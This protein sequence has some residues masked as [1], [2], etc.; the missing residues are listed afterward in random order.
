[1]KNSTNLDTKVSKDFITYANAVIKSRAIS[2]VKDNLKPVHRRILYTMFENKLLHNKKTVK[3]SN[4]V[5]KVMI[6]H[7][8]ADAS[9]YNAMVRLAQPWKMRYPLVSVQGNSGNI[10]GDGPAAM[11]YTEARLSKLGEMMMT[12]IHKKS[13]DFKES[14]DGSTTEPIVLPSGFPNILCNG[15]V[16][17]A[18]GTST[19]VVPHNLTEVC[20]GILAYLKSPSITTE[21]L[22]KYIPAP[23]FPTGGTITN[24]DVIKEIY[25]TGRGTVTLRSKY[26]IENVGVK[27]HI[28]IEEVPY[29][30]TLEDGFIKP[31]KKLVLEDGFDLI[32]DFKNN[33]GKGGIE[34]RII[35]KK[36]ANVYKVLEAIW[37]KTRLE[38]TQRIA[39]T[40]IVDGNPQ[41]LGLKAMIKY[42]IEHRNEIFIKIAHYDLAKTLRREQVINALIKALA[43]IDEV[44]ALIKKSANT[45]EANLKIMQLLQI[46]ASQASSILDMK[47]SRLSKLDSMELTNEL[48]EL[49]KKIIEL[50]D[51]VSNEATRTAM[52][53]K[54]IGSLKRLYGDARRTTL[55]Y[56]SGNEAEGYPV[57]T[58]KMMMF[59]NGNTFVT[60]KKLADLDIGRKAA[61]LNQSPVVLMTNTQTDKTLN[62]FTQEGTM[63]QI[64]MLTMA[65]EKIETNTFNT[66]PLAAY[67]F[68]DADN[69][70]EYIVFV[71]SGG[72]VKKTA[73]TEY[74]KAKNNARTIKVKGDQELIFVGM[75]NNED[76]VAVLD[77]KLSFFKVKSITAT[78]KLTIGSKAN[79]SKSAVSA[80]IISDNES[81]LMLS[82]DGKGKLTKASELS[83][84]AKGGNGQVVAK[85]TVLVCRASKEYIINDGSKNIVINKTISTKGKT[86]IGSK[87]ITGKPVSVIG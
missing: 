13:V 55:I 46:T 23:D 64:K 71:T 74:I 61:E 57:E 49:Q 21:Q 25:E 87:I 53:K 45:A 22:M 27:Q 34:L 36:G 17:I 69:L 39:N 14:Y 77:T 16:G 10:S 65:T 84:T 2:D 40:V 54:E 5:G 29:L 82:A 42:Y 70:K 72:M 67:D 76:N 28:V 31:L 19:S 43:K 18:V 6:R 79:N 20:E 41:T 75:A 37:K 12:D 68:E 60:Q 4:I 83:L 86:A 80:A 85:D 78:S 38:I 32:D 8:H 58:V 52:I 48:E 9:I 62:I 44:I 33:T 47:L 56:G 81:L 15:N 51:I 66:L 24:A 73:T 35:L 30:I 26:R 3:S 1:M 63:Q 11:R 50:T 7:P 59:A